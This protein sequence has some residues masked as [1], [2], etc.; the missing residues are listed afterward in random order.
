MAN[1]HASYIKLNLQASKT[2]WVDR[3]EEDDDDE[4]SD[5]DSASDSDDEKSDDEAD[6]HRVCEDLFSSLGCAL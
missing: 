3:N 5:S 1:W 2:E 6:N 4:E